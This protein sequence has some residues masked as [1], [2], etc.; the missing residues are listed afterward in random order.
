MQPQKTKPKVI[1]PFEQ[2]FETAKKQTPEVAAFRPTPEQAPTPKNFSP[3]SFDKLNTAYAD[4]DKSSLDAVR[5][6]LPQNTKDQTLK[7][8]FH[9]RFK[10]EEEEYYLKMKREEEEKKRQ[11]E[12]QAQEKRRLEEEQKAKQETAP[13]KGKVRK[14][15]FGKS[16]KK[17][18]MV[19]PAEIKPGGG[20][21]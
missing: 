20:K 21:Q 6:E 14:N 3:M 9:K 12:L 16:A 11:E 5:G 15:I 4:Q 19:L 1:N 8:Q 17:A 7:L 10:R 2:S 18:D 13:P